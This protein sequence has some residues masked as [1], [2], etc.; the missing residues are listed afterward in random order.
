MPVL[1]TLVVA[2]WLA[3]GA[4]A[5]SVER[6][7]WFFFQGGDQTWLY[8]SA[9]ALSDGFLPPT[10]ISYAWPLL[11]APVALFAG[12][13]Y[14]A[15]LPAIVVLQ[16]LLLQPLA[17][18]CVYGIASRLGGRLVGYVAAA[19]WIA[20][21]FAII[22][23]WDPR[24]HER[25]VDQ[26]LP[27]ALGLTGMADYPS[28][29]A[30]LVAAYLTVRA[31]EN[32]SWA[33]GAA[34]GLAVGFAI[35]LKPSNAF[36]VVA[37]LAALAVA[38]RWRPAGAFALALA[39]ALLTLA[40]WKY[41]GLG[42]L[43]A[44]LFP[45]AR[46]AAGAV[47][48]TGPLDPYLSLDWQRLADNEAQLR[49]YFWSVRLLEWVPLV[50]LVGVARRSLPTAVLLGTWFVAFLLGKG[51]SERA[52]VEVGTF[53]RLLMPAYPAFFLLGVGILLVVPVLGGRLASLP[54]PHAPPLRAAALA[55]GAAVFALAPLAAVAAARPLPE[56]AVLQHVPSNTLVPVD[57]RLVPRV[58]G[59]GALVWQ[60]RSGSARPSYRV[61]R[62]P[63]EEDVVCGT[64]DPAVPRYCFLEMEV[65]DVTRDRTLRVD[66]GGGRW[67]YRIGVAASWNDDPQEGDVLF[68]S[69]PVVVDG[70][71]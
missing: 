17:L 60:E 7:G 22:P 52:G 20:A 62:A 29:V 39:P 26:F 65:V 69:A 30:A 18:L 35:G 12:P 67:A 71:R 59:G 8:S 55:T 1:A 56:P 33:D 3:T 25:Y 5:A 23:L 47:A 37:P 16:V 4:F 48:F 11:L 14:L 13:D 63:A 6:N 64:T 36:V 68:V 58:D 61:L 49:E 2:Q 15:A 45:E 43:P 19:A 40:L 31:L 44:F 21:P 53:F 9:W 42:Y 51:A 46:V 66:P 28:M 41:R 57:A 10:I 27:Q 24:Y 70:T 32:G 34:A 38:R 54:R 50:G